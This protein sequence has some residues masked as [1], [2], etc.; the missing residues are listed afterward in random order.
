MLDEFRD[1]PPDL[2]ADVH[3]AEELIPV[4]ERQAHDLTPLD[5]EPD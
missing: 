1:W 3:G 2:R 5:A 4:V